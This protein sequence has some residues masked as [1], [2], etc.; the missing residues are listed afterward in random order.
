MDSQVCLSYLELTLVCY[1]C[2]GVYLLPFNSPLVLL[3]SFILS[4][5]SCYY[6]LLVWLRVCPSWLYFQRSHSWSHLF[7][8]VSM[9]F[10]SALIF[11]NYFQLLIW[12]VFLVF[13]RPCGASLG[14]LRFVWI[15]DIGS[16]SHADLFKNHPC[17]IPK[18]LFGCIFT[19]IWS[20]ECFYFL[21]DFLSDLSSQSGVYDP[22]ST[23]F[24]GLSL[25]HTLFH[26]DLIKYRKLFHS[27]YLLILDFWPSMWSILE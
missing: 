13:S 14:C 21:Y 9:A 17:S 12:L 24:I 7:F 22:I 6:V 26:Y 10:I 18:V 8:S 16:H 5:L 11:I 19:L 20:L 4:S 23:C 15:F 1:V 27:Y 2:Q 25:S 3:A